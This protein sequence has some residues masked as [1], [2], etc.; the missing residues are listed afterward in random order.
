MT[1]FLH[2]S[3]S[4]RKH[5]S[6][7]RALA[8][9]FTNQWHAKFP[10]DKFI[11][12]DIGSAPP[13]FIS[14]E[15][16]A[17]VFTLEEKRT[18]KQNSLLT[19]SDMLIKEITE[20]DIIL[21]STPMYNYGMPASLKAWFDQVIRVN[22]TFT[23]DLDRGDFP[24]EPTL[25]GKTLVLLSACGEFGFDVGGVREEMNHLGP[26]IRTA[27][28]YLGVDEY[29]EVRIEYQEFG[30]QRHA[31]SIENAYSTISKVIKQIAGKK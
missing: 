30:D 19:L 10:T 23:L 29:Y 8:K 6:I 16:I 7:S 12:R 5:N 21:I 18:D 22:K 31:R 25:S 3:S 24:L 17:A 28:K 2:V 11:H 4:A 9:E 1:T 14:E 15:W 27:S 13:N 20:S 26:H